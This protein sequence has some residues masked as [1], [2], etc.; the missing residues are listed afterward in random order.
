MTFKL[1]NELANILRKHNNLSVAIQLYKKA[2][3]SIK[4]R[5]KNAYLE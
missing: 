5:Y 3:L 1:M 2:L 4:T